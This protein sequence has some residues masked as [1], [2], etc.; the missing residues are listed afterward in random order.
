M[1]TPK[2]VRS[3][4]PKLYFSALPVLG[5][6]SFRAAL[7]ASVVPCTRRRE[8]LELSRSRKV[9]G[10]GQCDIHGVG[11]GQCEIHGAGRVPGGS[12][13]GLPC[14]LVKAGRVKR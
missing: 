8:P 9:A 7:L 10:F 11:F 3:H 2:R 13:G 1:V 14:L 12:D 4:S 6:H 5:G